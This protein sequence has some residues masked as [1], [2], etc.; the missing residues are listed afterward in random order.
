MHVAQPV[1]GLQ[2]AV[3][4]VHASQAKL[5]SENPP[6][7]EQSTQTPPEGPKPVKHTEHVDEVAHVEQ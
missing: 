6:L 3:Q 5:P 4:P 2:A 1:E 7:A